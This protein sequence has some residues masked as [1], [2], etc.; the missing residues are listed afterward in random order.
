MKKINEFVNNNNNNN[1]N[2]IILN[3]ELLH[4]SIFT[5]FG[6]SDEDPWYY[7]YNYLYKICI[8][9]GFPNHYSY[10][11]KKIENIMKRLIYENVDYIQGY[12]I[13]FKFAE[14]EFEQKIIRF[15]KGEK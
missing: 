6:M 12:D 7:D 10:I 14:E 1:N 13:K 4:Y 15:D 5:I 8:K 11:K 3:D 9:Y 2:T